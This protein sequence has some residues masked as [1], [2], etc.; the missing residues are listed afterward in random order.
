[1]PHIAA[2]PK[3]HQTETRN[4]V[5]VRPD[6]RAPLVVRINEKA[7]EKRCNERQGDGNTNCVGHVVKIYHVYS[8]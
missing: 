7:V 4:S 3:L 8:P 6:L 2:L 5:F 1:M